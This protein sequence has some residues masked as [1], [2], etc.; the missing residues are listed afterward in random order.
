MLDLRISPKCPE[1]YIKL[2]SAKNKTKTCKGRRIFLVES[3]QEFPVNLIVPFCQD[4]QRQAPEHVVVLALH[5]VMVGGGLGFLGLADLDPD[6]VED[7]G[8]ASH[9]QQRAEDPASRAEIL[10]IFALQP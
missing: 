4:L 3:G 6:G 8:L 10:V 7:L 9:L 5:E 2:L 1:K